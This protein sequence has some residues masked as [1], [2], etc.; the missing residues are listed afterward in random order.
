MVG[1]NVIES[2]SLGGCVM[3]L[4]EMIGVLV[5]DTVEREVGGVAASVVIDGTQ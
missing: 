3:S 2:S 1:G 4:V 5:M